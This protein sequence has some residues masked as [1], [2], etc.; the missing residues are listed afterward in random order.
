MLT[1]TPKGTPV[2]F[3]RAIGSTCDVCT[4]GQVGAHPTETVTQA[5]THPGAPT[6]AV[7]STRK[8]SRSHAMNGD[9]GYGVSSAFFKVGEGQP[10]E[11]VWIPSHPP[12]LLG[13]SDVGSVAGCLLVKMWTPVGL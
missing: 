3:W 5:C 13:K 1:L 2:P 4:P 9:W 6:S 8:S 11:T 10:R 7:H 12:S